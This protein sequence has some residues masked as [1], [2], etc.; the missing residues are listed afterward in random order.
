MPKKEFDQLVDTYVR[1]RYS[2]LQEGKHTKKIV[3]Q[4]NVISPKASG[5]FVVRKAQFD[6]D[7][8]RPYQKLYNA[9]FL[10]QNA[11]LLHLF[12]KVKNTQG[13]DVYIQLLS[14]PTL[15][16]IATKVPGGQ[17]SVLYT[18]LKHF[19]DG[20]VEEIDLGKTLPV[21]IHSSTQLVKHSQ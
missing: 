1:L 6:S 7:Y 8:N 9:Q 16:T 20:S 18:A 12:Y 15:D 11:P 19:L 13:E 21:T 10:S 5:T 3:L 2:I 17:A 14:F 4:N